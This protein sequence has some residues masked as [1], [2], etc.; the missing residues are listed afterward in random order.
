MDIWVEWQ[1]VGDNYI[2]RSYYLL[3]DYDVLDRNN[4]C[5]NSIR[6]RVI[7]SCLDVLILSILKAKRPSIGAIKLVLAVVEHNA[8]TETQ[9]FFFEP[10][11]QHLDSLQLSL[12][13]V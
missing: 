11:V 7:T 13:L 5:P 1:L 9:R 6:I 12:D 2:C 3:L 8:M 4:V 10:S